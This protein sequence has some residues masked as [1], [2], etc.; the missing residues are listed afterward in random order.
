MNPFRF[1]TVTRPARRTSFL[2]SALIGTMTASL[3]PAVTYFESNF[4]SDTVGEI[5]SSSAAI[6]PFA[7]NATNGIIVVGTGSTPAAISGNQSAYFYDL[8]TEATTRWFYELNSGTNVD[9]LQVDLDFR[10]GY[11]PAD[12]ENDEVRFILSAGRA[13]QSLPNSDFRPFEVR[14]VNNG[15]IIA[16]S[17]E[18]TATIITIDPATTHHLTLLINS[19]D[20]TAA[21]YADSGFGASSVPA[22]SFLVAV[23][24]AVI[25]TY[26]FIQTPDPTNAPEIDFYAENNDLGQFG[27][28]QD[29]AREGG[30]I[31]DNLV[32]QSFAGTTT[33]TLNAPSGLSAAAAS[34]SSI[35]LSWTDNAANEEGF[36]LERRTGSDAFATIATLS[37]DT[38][39]YTDTGLTPETTYDYRVSAT[40]TGFDHATSATASATTSAVAPLT[41]PYYS[42]NFESDTVGERPAGDYYGSPGS[43]TASNGFNVVGT[44]STPAA[45]DGTKSLHLFD[46]APDAVTR[47]FFPFAN[48]TNLSAVRVDVDFRRTAAPADPEDGNQR[49]GIALGRAGVDLANSDFRPFEVRLFQNGNVGINYIEGSSTVGTYPADATNRLTLLVNSHDSSAAAFSGTALGTGSV[50]PNTVQV[51]INN[52]LIGAYL[53]HQTPDPTNAPEVDFYASNDDLGQIGF[54][55]DSSRLFD[56]IIDNVLIQSLNGSE[57]LGSGVV[58]PTL[59]APTGVAATTAS[60][61]AINLTWTDAAD[62]ES[63]YIV[64]RRTGSGDFT[65][66]ATLAANSNSFSDTGLTAATTY[67][68]RVSATADGFD[69]ASAAIVSAT[70]SASGTLTDPYYS[71][72][73]ETDTV[74]ERPAGD[75]YGSPGSDTATNGFHVVGTGSTPAAIDGDQS[76]YFFDQAADAV[77]RWFFPFA[78][79]AN[80]SNARVDFDFRRTYT[81]TDPE[82]S[83]QRLAFTLGRAGEDVHNSD[84]RP[85]EFRVHQ[86]GNLAINGV[87]GSTTIGS[88]NPAVTNHVTLLVNS[89]DTNAVAFAGTAL[90]SGSVA[91][92]SVAV[93]LNN[94]FIGTY[95]FHQTP[96]PTN[97]PQVDFYASNNDLGQMGIYADSSRQAGFVIDNV[98]IQSLNGSETLGTGGNTGGG[99]GGDPVVVAPTVGAIDAP[100]AVTAGEDASITVTPEGTGPFTY[101]WYEGESGDTATPIAG[102]TGATLDLTALDATTSVW[103]RVTNTAGSADTDTITITATPRDE[104]IVTTIAELDAALTAAVPGRTILLAAGTWTDTVIRLHGTGTATQPITVGAVTP[105]ETIL[106]GGSRAELSGEYLVLRDLVFRDSYTGNDDEIIQ[107]RRSDGTPAHHSRVTNVTIEDYY[108]AAGTKVYYV[109][110]FGTNNRIDHNTFIGHDVP[111]VTV[112]VWFD[113][114]PVNHRIDHNRFADRIYGGGENGWESIRIGDS[115]STQIDANC[116]V[117]YNTFDHVDGEVE[118]ISNKTHANTYRYN[119]FFE[120]RGTLTLRHGDRCI[121][122]GNRFLGGNREA[123]GGVRVIGADHRIINNHFENLQPDSMGAVAVYAGQ[124][125]PSSDGYPAAHRAIIAHNTFIN[126]DGPSIELGTGEGSRDRDV[127]PIGGEIANNL[128]A[129]TT[130]TTQALITGPAIAQQTWGHNLYRDGDAS[131]LPTGA[132]TAAALTFTYDETLGWYRTATDSPARD[133]AGALSIPVSRDLFGQPRDASP[134]LGAEELPTS[135]GGSGG[136]PGTGNPGTGNPNPNEPTEAVSIRNYSAR[137]S[138]GSGDQLLINGIVIGGTESKSLLIRAVGPGLAHFGVSDLMTTPELVVHTVDG[139]VLARNAGWEESDAAGITTAS[140]ATGAFA[141]RAGER[142]AA[143]VVELAPGA[144]TSHVTANGGSTGNVLLETYDLTPGTGR[145]LNQSI[146]GTIGTGDATLMGGFAV[147]GATSRR[148]LIRCAGP[149]LLQF[150][151]NAPAA[152]PAIVVY[153]SQGNEVGRNDNWSAGANATSVAE[154]IAASGAFTFAAGSS[155]AA[156]V[157]TLPPGTYTYHANAAS[158]TPGVAIIEAYLLED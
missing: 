18:G 49:F 105:G 119:T 75:Y 132:L 90:G 151:V 54:Y 150:G 8:S 101:Q 103:L 70:T 109:S 13:G 61:T 102:A 50:A 55:A 136:N 111:G 39:S 133:A 73:F 158:G 62:N 27:F 56:M 118:I 43:N 129:H 126:I 17:A 59:N 104:V 3:L 94:V 114:V 22:N 12:P 64:E 19:H 106:Q 147:H 31:V 60:S 85:F 149:G 81:P 80:L 66:I 72:N 137:G 99:G 76:L 155:D 45:I 82:D 148:V 53:F 115:S 87:D 38:T 33:P 52:E 74:G 107:F 128:F 6:S 141:L 154:A 16:R 124:T 5:P 95:L 156:I 37:A 108:P 67:D 40:A 93:F 116:I 84:F 97:A 125:N 153:D 79:G 86:N 34:S 11:A 130:S 51:Y 96:D 26:T 112:V 32:L 46:A 140:A 110:V 134:D 117:E 120:S 21:S 48:D 28:F 152:D 91:T 131:G 1:L 143:L 121:V 44:G 68:Y 145:L 63:G 77:T 23:D 42:N 14:L 113:G 57:T 25:G 139:A 9:N 10:P 123:A 29:T 36:L 146:R 20:S 83:N 138:S 98:L 24:N 142:D 65:T 89:H 47:W 7:N 127:L 78:G 135:T 157:L 69:P 15:K 58:V 122:E 100:A 144:Y 41:D 92:N 88:Y 2:T 35:Q 71:N 4:E 30:L